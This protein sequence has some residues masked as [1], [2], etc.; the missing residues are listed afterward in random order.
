[1]ETAIA[2]TRANVSALA[3]LAAG[4]QLSI[5]D[6]LSISA[7]NTNDFSINAVAKARKMD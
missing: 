5:T 2:V 4:A 6:D 1:M 7:V 3:R